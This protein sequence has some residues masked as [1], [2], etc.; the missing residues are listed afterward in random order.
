VQESEVEEGKATK[1]EA[2][3]VGIFFTRHG[4]RVCAL[5][6]RC[7]HAGGPLDEGAIQGGTVKCPWHGSVF[8][9]EDG[10]IKQGPAR[11]PQP[12]Y[13]TRVIDGRVEVRSIE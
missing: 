13:E 6:D 2:D 12:A 11:A 10:S 3:G 5:S 1:V 7:T 9:L 8:S 4:G